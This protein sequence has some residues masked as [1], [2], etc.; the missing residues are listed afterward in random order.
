MKSVRLQGYV[1]YMMG[2]IYGTDEF[3]LS[4]NERR[5]DGWSKWWWWRKWTRLSV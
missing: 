5:S 3:Q 4:A 2:K 1:K